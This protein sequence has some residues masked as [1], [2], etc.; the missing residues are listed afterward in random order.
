M[1]KQVLLAVSLM[2]A[3]WCTAGCEKLKPFLPQIVPPTP[4]AVTNIIPPVVPVPT[5]AVTNAAL[6]PHFRADDFFQ[7]GN[8]NENAYREQAIVSGKATGCLRVKASYGMGDELGMTVPKGKAE[9]HLLPLEHPDKPGYYL[10]ADGWFFK[11]EAGGVTRWIHDMGAPS[12]ADAKRWLWLTKSP[13]YQ[14]RLQYLVAANAAP[15][16]V[17]YIRETAAAN[18]VEVVQESP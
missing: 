5:P 12:M 14:N 15:E 11:A 13:Y 3:V 9:M 8:P 10:K 18:K 1:K 2:V 4:P 7:H 17:A 16:V 6:W